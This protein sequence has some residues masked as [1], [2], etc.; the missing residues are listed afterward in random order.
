MGKEIASERSEGAGDWNVSAGGYFL[1]GRSS[2][3]MIAVGKSGG[4]E[5][6]APPRRPEVRSAMS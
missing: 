6:G 2:L 1:N 3:R 5:G 4:W